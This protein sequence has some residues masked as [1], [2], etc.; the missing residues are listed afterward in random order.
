[1]LVSVFSCVC[2]FLC[3]SVL[4]QGW[5]DTVTEEQVEKAKPHTKPYTLNP[6]PPNPMRSLIHKP[7]LNP[8]LETLNLNPNPETPNPKI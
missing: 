3:L 5:P 8:N 1:M 6:K 2:L 7:S 4:V